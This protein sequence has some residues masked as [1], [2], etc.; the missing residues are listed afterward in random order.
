VQPRF[1]TATTGPGPARRTDHG[2]LDVVV[3]TSPGRAA[4]ATTSW[5]AD[6]PFMRSLRERPERAGLAGWI[7]VDLLL[8][9]E[10]S[11]RSKIANALIAIAA[12]VALANLARIRRTTTFV[13]PYVLYVLLL[14]VAVGSM[15]TTAHEL[16]VWLNADGRIV[17]AV[18]PL[19]ALG[20]L[21]IRWADL[22]LFVKAIRV[23]VWADVVLLGAALAGVGPIHRV[24]LHKS[25]FFG[26]TSSHH[27]AGYFASA[28]ILI[29]YGARKTP[30]LNIK[31]SFL[32]IGAAAGLVIATGSR[33][34]LIG[35]AGVALWMLLS[36]R[37]ASD[38]LKVLG[39]SIAIAVWDQRGLRG[40]HPRAVLVL[41]HRHL[42][43]P[44]QPDPRHRQLPLQRHQPALLRDPARGRLRHLGRRQQCRPRRCPRPVPRCARRDRCGRAGAAADDVDLAVP[45]PAPVED[46]TA[47]DHPVG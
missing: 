33:T 27:A 35:L 9:A 10:L 16:N 45:G 24:V 29:L 19:V 15:P 23:I 5:L 1:G 22:R 40:E 6:T 3:L 4:E 34:S 39:G 21:T 44:A 30:A 7:G 41:G 14:A 20:T 31:P 11:G 37:R 18:I 32:T 43:V 13:L 38:I 12:L 2:V 25:N 28:A 42:D 46:Q 36:Q 47:A 8:S 17:I 26:L